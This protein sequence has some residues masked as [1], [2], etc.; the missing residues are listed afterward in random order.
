MDCKICNAVLTFDEILE[1]NARLCYACA[2]EERES[3]EEAL[4]RLEALGVPDDGLDG[5]AWDADWED[6]DEPWQ[7]Y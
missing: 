7:E 5:Y 1:H 6:K 3:D 4:E 2:A